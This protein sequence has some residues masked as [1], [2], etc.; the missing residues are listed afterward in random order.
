M[1][2]PKVRV[3]IPL[4]EKLERLKAVAPDDVNAI[5]TLVDAALERH[6]EADVVRVRR[7]IRL[8]RT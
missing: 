1:D 3:Q 2:E 6:E 7:W 4:T 8:I 5:E